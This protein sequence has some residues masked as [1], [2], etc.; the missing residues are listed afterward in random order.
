MIARRALATIV[1]VTAC[2]RDIRLG[3]GVG[4]ASVDAPAD[5]TGNPFIPGSYTMHFLDPAAASCDGSL[6]GQEAMF[7]LLTTADQ[8]F[9]DGGVVVSTPNP[10]ALALAGDPVMSAVMQPAITLMPGS[11]G[12]PPELWDAVVMGSF[13]TGPVT[14]NRTAIDLAVDSTT[15]QATAGIEG[16]LT[17]LFET[18]DTTGSC[19]VAFGVTLTRP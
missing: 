3:G 17:E 6:V 11:P 7:A 16:Q 9:V 19:N 4:D 8:R 2:G 12:A 18:A 15:A 1:I 13:G 10:T 14:T 5:G